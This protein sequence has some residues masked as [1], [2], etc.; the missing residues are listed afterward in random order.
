MRSRKS[1]PRRAQRRELRKRT[2][3]VSKV[4]KK[5]IVKGS[6]QDRERENPWAPSWLEITFAPGPKEQHQPSPKH[7]LNLH[8]L[9]DTSCYPQYEG[10]HNAASG[11]RL[12]PAGLE[13][14]KKQRARERTPNYSLWSTLDTR[15]SPVKEGLSPFNLLCFSIILTFTRSV[16]AFEILN[17]EKKKLHVN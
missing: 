10:S 6:I 7:Y 8:I 15:I 4:G 5:S 14:K 2:S 17:E 11:A 16:H 1:F 9:R 13:K 12:C 3:C